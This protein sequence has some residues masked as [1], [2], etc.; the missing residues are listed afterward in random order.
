MV[1]TPFF[2]AF[3]SKPGPESAAGPAASAQ[4]LAAAAHQA[5][6]LLRIAFPETV[7]PPDLLRLFLCALFGVAINQMMFF[8]GLMRTSPMNSSIIMVVTPILVLVLS[9][10]LIGERIT[11]LH[12]LTTHMDL[13]EQV[14]VVVGDLS[15]LM[16]AA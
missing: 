4:R 6:W 5:F 14:D 2:T 3:P 13:P 15:E 1:V 16:G 11:W 7:R 12:G 10:L 8:E 9:A